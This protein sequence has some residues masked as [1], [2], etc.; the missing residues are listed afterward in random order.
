VARSP[1]L[2][3]KEAF[4]VIKKRLGKSNPNVIYLSILVR[5]MYSSAY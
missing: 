1:P 3:A 4:K 5:F 2:S